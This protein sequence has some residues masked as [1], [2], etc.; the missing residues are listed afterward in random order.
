MPYEFFAHTADLGIRVVA[1]GREELFAEAGRALMNALVENVDAVQAVCQREIN[2]SG[3]RLDDLLYDWLSELL[4]LFDT[5]RVVFC[6]FDVSL[7]G[8]SMFHLKGKAWG[9]PLDR[10]RH[11]LHLEVKAIT[12]HRL[13]V[14]PTAEGSWEAE[15]IADL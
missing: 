14:E 11:V 3:D 13:R 4:Y 1:S 8:D 10:K 2:L 12:Y 9:E 5:Q 15:I 7:T 6:R